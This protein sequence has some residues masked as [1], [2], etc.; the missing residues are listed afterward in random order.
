MAIIKHL[1]TLSLGNCGQR[2]NIKSS[3]VDLPLSSEVFR[4]KFPV[5]YAGEVNFKTT[6]SVSDLDK[7]FGEKLAYF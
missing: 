1:S 2:L 7:V 3:A 6:L 5:N 4:Q